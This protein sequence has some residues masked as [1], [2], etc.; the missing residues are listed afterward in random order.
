MKKFFELRVL[1]GWETMGVVMA[2]LGLAAAGIY[3]DNPWLRGTSSWLINVLML[4]FLMCQLLMAIRTESRHRRFMQYTT[5]INEQ[6][7]QAQAIGTR[8]AMHRD[9][10]DFD[11]A[12]A[13]MEEA[14]K[15]MDERRLV[16]QDS[17]SK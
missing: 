7:E 15:L 16:W 2:T 14:G 17:V 10:E 1:T 5:R 8:Y 11:R 6:L 12:K 3:N 13:H 4:W 9:P